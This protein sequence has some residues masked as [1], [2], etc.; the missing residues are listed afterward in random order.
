MRIC[1]VSDQAFPAQGGEGVAIQGFCLKLQQK[2]HQIIF[3]TSRVPHPPKV[4]KIKV[5]RFLSVPISQERGYF[6]FP[7]LATLIF[8][9]K[10]ERVEIVHSNLP[11][12]FGWQSVRAARRLKIPVVLGFH[13][14]IGNVFPSSSA[15]LLPFKWLTEKWFS[16]YYCQGNVNVVVTPSFFARD[17]LRKYSS[18][19]VEVVSNG[20]DMDIFNYAQIDK[21]KSE[22]FREKYGL[23]KDPL[24]LYA[25]RLSRE[26]NV[27]YLLSIMSVLH[28]DSF[29]VRLLIVGRGSL[30]DKLVK[31][32]FEMGLDKSVI[33]TNYLEGK[34]LIC[35]Y[36]EAEIFILPSFY[37]LQS[38]VLL[39]AMAMK[40]AILVSDSKD[41]AAR[42]LVREGVNG[43]T[44]SL[45]DPQDAVRK[46]KRII[47]S[48][49]LKRSMQEE[50]LK[51]AYDHNID[52]SVSKIEALYKDLARRSQ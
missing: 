18:R 20:V 16:Y 3:L 36:R 43:Y 37:E 12:F 19:P 32:S 52:K 2:G 38:I 45:A 35:A 33:F 14:Q 27:E 23:G 26:K 47:S 40:N 41:S 31:R 4:R 13:V 25:G 44:F 10:K 6:A 7:N 17:T 8:I 46:I 48:E 50:S 5:F 51:V 29:P 42:E 30:K 15:F 28:Q 49:N 34:E 21:G 9:L 1:V 11:T 39:E 24:L 22:G